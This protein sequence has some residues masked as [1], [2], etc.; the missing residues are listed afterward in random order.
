MRGGLW[1]RLKQVSH[2]F[3]LTL[4]SMVVTVCLCGLTN[5]TLPLVTGNFPEVN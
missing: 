3:F 1:V 2:K 5:N 4:L